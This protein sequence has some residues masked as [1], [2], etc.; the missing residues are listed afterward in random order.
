MFPTATDEFHLSQWETQSAG[1]FPVEKIPKEMVRRKPAFI[2]T[3]VDWEGKIA[4]APPV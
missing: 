2:G 1:A 3:V 4:T